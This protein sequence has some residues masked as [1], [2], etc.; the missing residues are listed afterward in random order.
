MPKLQ[1]PYA[2]ALRE[3][4]IRI[5]AIGSGPDEDVVTESDRRYNRALEDVMMMIKLLQLTSCPVCGGTFAE[6]AAV[7]STWTCTGCGAV[8]HFGSGGAPEPAT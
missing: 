2:A 4:G 3:V 5:N 8:G 1:G 6:N 7:E